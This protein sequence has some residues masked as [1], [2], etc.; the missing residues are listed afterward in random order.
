MRIRRLR[1]LLCWHKFERV[2][3]FFGGVFRCKRCDGVYYEVGKRKRYVG[4]YSEMCSGEE[5]A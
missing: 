2:A 5:L 3:D 4:Q 1:H